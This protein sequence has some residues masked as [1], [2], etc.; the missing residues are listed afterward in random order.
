M[1]REGRE[2]RKEGR[3][4]RDEVKRDEVKREKERTSFEDL[5]VWV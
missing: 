4:S 1:G 3:R 2:V 5:H